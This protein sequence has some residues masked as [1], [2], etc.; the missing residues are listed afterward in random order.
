MHLRCRTLATSVI[1]EYQTIFDRNNNYYNYY[2]EIILYLC[3]SVLQLTLQV[4]LYSI[5]LV[6]Q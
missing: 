2:T 5:R 6:V 4:L 3:V 1:W